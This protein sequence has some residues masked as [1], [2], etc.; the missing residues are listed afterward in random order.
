MYGGVIYG[1]PQKIQ[2]S[3]TKK[4]MPLGEW[5]FKMGG[6]IKGVG[7]GSQSPPKNLGLP[8]RGTT[9]CSGP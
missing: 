6:H 2:R 8:V 5:S 1:V 3:P 9:L 4:I 7:G